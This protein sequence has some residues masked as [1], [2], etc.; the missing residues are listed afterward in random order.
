MTEKDAVKCQHF[1]L[2]NIW[3]LAMDVMIEE[4]LTAVILERLYGSKTLGLA[5]MP[6][7]QRPFAL[8]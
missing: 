1:D 3:V 5:R 7:M 6:S 4:N 2:K 8:R